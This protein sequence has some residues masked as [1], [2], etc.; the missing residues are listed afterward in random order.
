ERVRERGRRLDPLEALARQ[1]ELT[2]ERR[3]STERMECRADVVHESRERELGGAA[4]AADRVVR[5]VHGD[6]MPVARELDGCRQA[7]R[8]AADHDRV[9]AHARRR[10]RSNQ[11]SARRSASMRFSVTRKPCPS[12]GYTW[13]SWTFPPSRRALTTCSASLRG[14]RGSFSPWRTSRGDRIFEAC[15]S[16]QR[17]RQRCA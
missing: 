8:P 6:G 14:T 15:V 11:S 2:E 10:C 3:R 4:A 17:S 5:F 13:Y 16:G 7:I 1:I 9:G 12:P